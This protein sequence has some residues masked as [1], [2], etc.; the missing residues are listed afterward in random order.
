ML[1]PVL[2][3]RSSGK[4]KLGRSWGSLPEMRGSPAWPGPQTSGCSP[5]L[6]PSCSKGTVRGL[7]VWTGSLA[8]PRH[9]YDLWTGGRIPVLFV[10]SPRRAPSM[11]KRQR[12][13][14]WVISVHPVPQA[15]P[16]RRGL[17]PDCFSELLPYWPWCNAP[18]LRVLQP[19]LAWLRISQSAT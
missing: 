17:A 4:S 7:A 13:V 6:C 16:G 9:G 14:V 1:G 3:K 18:R 8:L 12:R 5:S 19:G 2:G 10:L 15:R 11:Q